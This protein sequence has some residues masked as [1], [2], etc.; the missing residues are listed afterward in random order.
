MSLEKKKKE[1]ELMRVT[2]ARQE[3]ELR[4]EERLDEIKRLK[5]NIEIQLKTEEKIKQDLEQ[6]NKG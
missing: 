5:E 3:M 2:L 1:L 4:I 6:F